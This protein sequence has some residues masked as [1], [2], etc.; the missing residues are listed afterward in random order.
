MNMTGLS[1]MHSCTK[2]PCTQQIQHTKRSNLLFK[3][4]PLFQH[5]I[6]SAH[7]PLSF[8]GLNLNNTMAVQIHAVVMLDLMQTSQFAHFVKKIDTKQ[9]AKHPAKSLPIYPSP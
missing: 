5:S 4:I 7:E 6:H 9:M 1:I 2:S 3:Q 8:Y